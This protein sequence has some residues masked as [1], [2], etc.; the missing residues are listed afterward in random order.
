MDKSKS[1]YILTDKKLSQFCSTDKSE[2]ESIIVDEYYTEESESE[3]VH[4]SINTNK[5][6]NKIYETYQETLVIDNPV[7]N[8]AIYF[9]LFECG[10]NILNRIDATCERACMATSREK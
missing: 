9:N 2:S 10:E 5:I 6:K 4:K 1:K 3:S 8:G 7:I